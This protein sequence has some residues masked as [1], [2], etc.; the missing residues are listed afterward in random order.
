MQ[1]LV[2]YYL[3]PLSAGVGNRSQI[4][5]LFDHSGVDMGGELVIRELFAAKQYRDHCEIS[6]YM[7]SCC[8]RAIKVL[9]KCGELIW[10]RTASTNAGLRGYQRVE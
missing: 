3:F 6:W 9:N 5:A 4:A 1:G 7:W 8:W 2:R 10:L